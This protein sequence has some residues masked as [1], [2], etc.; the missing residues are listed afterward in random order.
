MTSG[1]NSSDC[2]SLFSSMNLDVRFQLFL[3]C[4]LKNIL[5]HTDGTTPAK[6]QL[7]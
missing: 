7:D 4:L 3:S 5:F 2:L 6:I 1:I